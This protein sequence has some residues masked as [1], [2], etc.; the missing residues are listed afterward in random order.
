MASSADPHT[1]VAIIGAGLSGI[2]MG[3]QLKRKLGHVNF[4]I[5]E[6]TD[7]VGRTW[8][9]NT[10]SFSSL[11]LSTLSINGPADIPISAAILRPR[12]VLFLA[13]LPIVG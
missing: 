13:L 4:E 11:P 12:C 9:Q 3:V 2:A 6:I 1:K 10:C 8:S 7:D 5:F